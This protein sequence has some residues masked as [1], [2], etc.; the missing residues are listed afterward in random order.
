M[1]WGAQFFIDVR[2]VADAQAWPVYPEPAR[3]SEPAQD[4]DPE[5]APCCGQCDAPLPPELRDEQMCE[6]CE[7]EYVNPAEWN[8]RHRADR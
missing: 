7:L 6:D 4:A 1:T 8:R 3:D 5:E 2:F